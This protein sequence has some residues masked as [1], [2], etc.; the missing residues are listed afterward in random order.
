M[1]L[2]PIVEYSGFLAHPD[3]RHDAFAAVVNS[4]KWP[5]AVLAD[6][7]KRRRQTAGDRRKPLLHLHADQKIHAV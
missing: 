3:A 7:G 6:R 4:L 2:Q 1:C 5:E